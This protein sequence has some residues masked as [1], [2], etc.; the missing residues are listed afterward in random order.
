MK[1]VSV[2]LTFSPHT[3]VLMHR[4]FLLVLMLQL[5]G[6]SHYILPWSSFLLHAW[7]W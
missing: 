2:I 6:S 5:W 1:W 7:R 4:V 3:Q